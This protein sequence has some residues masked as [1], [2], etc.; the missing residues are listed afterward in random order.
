MISPS[1]FTRP[2]SKFGL[3]RSLPCKHSALFHDDRIKSSEKKINKATLKLRLR[4]Q[5][6]LLQQLSDVTASQLSSRRVYLTYIAEQQ[7]SIMS[8]VQRISPRPLCHTHRLH[9]L[10][11]VLFPLGC[12]SNRLDFY[13]R[14]HLWRRDEAHMTP[15]A[16][17][18]Q[19]NMPLLHTSAHNG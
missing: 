12:H 4:C 1:L 15:D 19:D 7:R 13:T 8:H 5:K 10:T 2:T 3:E 11:S 16:A 9:Q 6:Y 17:L 14:T 18:A